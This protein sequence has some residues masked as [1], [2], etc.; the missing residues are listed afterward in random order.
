MRRHI[1]WW[2][3]R[4]PGTGGQ[5]H[6]FPTRWPCKV[7]PLHSAS[8]S[9]YKTGAWR[10]S[11]G[12]LM[13]PKDRFPAVQ[14]D[15]NYW[16]PSRIHGKALRIFWISWLVTKSEE[17][18]IAFLNNSSN[19]AGNT[20][21]GPPTKKTKDAREDTTKQTLQFTWSVRSVTVNQRFIAAKH[22]D[23]LETGVT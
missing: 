23:L 13:K 15:T 22:V 2:L 19:K 14:A 21:N 4:K 17:T 5:P 3:S 7:P 12:V 9:I 10:P 11:L 18:P 20:R 16:K 8:T 1:L 6:H